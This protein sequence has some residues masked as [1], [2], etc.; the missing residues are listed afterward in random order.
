MT[1]CAWPNQ[2]ENPLVSRAVW[3]AVKVTHPKGN[4]LKPFAGR[5]YSPLV[6]RVLQ[7]C[8]SQKD[9]AEHGMPF[10]PEFM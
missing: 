5:G 6:P 3:A 8:R 2:T 9:N 4:G 10:C 7:D 1:L